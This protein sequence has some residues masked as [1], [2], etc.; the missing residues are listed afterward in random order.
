MKLFKYRS[1]IAVIL[2][3]TL[4]LVQMPGYWTGK[5]EGCSMRYQ[6]RGRNSR[7][8]NSGDSIPI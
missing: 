8:R 5:S 3:T 2:A 1:H 6:F 4:P 7:G